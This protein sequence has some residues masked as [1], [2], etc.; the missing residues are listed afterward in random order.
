MFR[1]FSKLCLSIL[2]W[3]IKGEF[4]DLKKY[5]ITVA[6]HTSNWDFFVAIL[7]RSATRLK[8]N[9]LGK[10]AL[11]KAPYGWIFRAMGGYPVD[12]SKNTNMVDK[13]IEIYNNADRFCIAV[14]PEGTRKKVKEWKTGFYYIADGAKIPIV[15][16]SIDYAQKVVEISMPF[17]T[18]GD[19]EK[20]MP[21]IK[22]FY[23][24]K[25]G[26]AQL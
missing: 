7:V 24:G 4:P 5:I 6:P 3:K 8:S 13:V 18:S 26:K 1:L 10:L 17:Y 15:M 21:L 9:F 16:A 2:G 22:A 11:F 14:A 25:K 19:I 20:D 12:R 23:E